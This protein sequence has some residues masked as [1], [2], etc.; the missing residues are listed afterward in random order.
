MKF[1][2]MV[3]PLTLACLAATAL[4]A[5]AAQEVN[6]YT[7]REKGLIEPLLQ[8]FSK[9]TGIKHNVVY[10]K[11]GLA[12]RVSSE[13]K[14][15]PADVLM[16]VD[17]G[18]LTNLVDQGLSQPV[19]SS[20][21]QKAIPAQYRDANNH[22]FA[23]S[24]RDR[25]LYVNKNLNLSSF[26][27]EDLADPKWKGRVCIRSGQHPYNT[28]LISALLA[29]N[30]VV[31]T[32]K[33]LEGVKA[34]LARKATGGDRDVA[35]DILAGI[36]DIGIANSYYVGKMTTNE[37][38]PVQ[39]EWV[40]AIKV[41]RPTF[42]NA[43]NSGTH[44]NVS[45]AVVA[46][47]APNKANAVKLL[48]FLVSPEAQALYANYNFE[49]PVVA[50]AKVNPIIQALGKFVPDSLPM[51]EIPKYRKKASELVQRVGFDN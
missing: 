10:M 44:A 45:G 29:H 37:K 47:N 1:S 3:K 43:K 21:L 33:W 24:L 42:A 19:Y 40:K 32:E 8:Q 35:R 15:S 26:H 6:V 51:S 31:A 4:T 7:T 5:N 23:L 17:I 50:G 25:V 48:E 27:Y 46:K 20:K 34:N 12:E 22:W 30:G 28:S 13:G 38:Q 49:Y 41:V 16:V 39:K 36:C 2:S 11:D 14:K 9:A 18:Q